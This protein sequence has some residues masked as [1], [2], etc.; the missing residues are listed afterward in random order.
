MIINCIDNNDIIDN[1]EKNIPLM[2]RD[3]GLV[4]YHHTL[5]LIK[6]KKKNYC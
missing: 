1:N 6:E 2:I 5:L 4:S 3:I